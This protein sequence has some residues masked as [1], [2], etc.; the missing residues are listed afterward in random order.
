MNYIK[1]VVQTESIAPRKICKV[2]NYPSWIFKDN[3][4]ILGTLGLTMFSSL[5]KVANFYIFFFINVVT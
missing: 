5:Q 1:V 4:T 2:M 3:L